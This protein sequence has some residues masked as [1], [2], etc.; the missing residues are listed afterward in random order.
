M[1]TADAFYRY[2]SEGCASLAN[3]TNCT[4]PINYSAQQARFDAREEW[5]GKLN[6]R[7]TRGL[8]KVLTCQLY[9]SSLPARARHSHCRIDR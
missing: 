1:S 3:R 6:S 9:T 8:N 2:Q 7:L 5:M 4:A